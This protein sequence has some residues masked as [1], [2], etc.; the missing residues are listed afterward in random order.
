[1]LRSS[2]YSPILSVSLALLTTLTAS[3][4]HARRAGL[5]VEGCNGCHNGGAAPDI[6]V[7][8]SPSNPAPGE[9]A[10]LQVQI[11]AGNINVGGLYLRTGAG[12]LATIDGQGTKLVDEHQLVHD[13]PKR[14][15]GSPGWPSCSTG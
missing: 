1:M 9:T 8:L 5:V 12:R 6:T 4:A 14:A 3:Q 7:N 15:S 10:T 11:A 2:L 13:A